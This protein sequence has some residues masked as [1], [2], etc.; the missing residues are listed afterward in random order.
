MRLSIAQS[1]LQN[2]VYAAAQWDM[3]DYSNTTATNPTGYVISS[4]PAVS[5]PLTVNYYEDYTAPGQPAYTV[6]TTAVTA[7]KGLLTATRTAVLNN[8]SDMLWTIDYYDGLGRVIQTYKEHYLGGT[9]STGNYDAVA[10]TYDFMNQPLTVSRQHYTAAKG[11]SPALTIS[12]TYVYDHTERR[13]QT[14]EQL[15][16]G[17]NVQLSE[18]EYNEIGQLRT[19]NLHYINNGQSQGVNITLG[20]ADAVASGS[21]T[22]IASGS[23]QLNPGFSVALNANFS[24]Q[25]STYEQSVSYTYNE[26]GWLLS[27]SAP[28]FSMQLGYNSGSSPQYNGNISSQS[29]TSA[30]S[31]GSFNYQYDALNRLQSGATAD[32]QYIER[33]ISYDVE[34]NIKTLSRVYGGTLVDS[35]SYAYNDASCNAT[36]QFQTITDLSADAGPSGYKT[37]TNGYLYDNNGN[38]VADDSK[39]ITGT[40]GI[41]YNLLNLPQSI[42]AKGTVYTYSASGEKLRR[43]VTTGGTTQYTDYVDGIEYDGTGNTNEAITFIQ[44]EEGRALPN[45]SDWNYEYNLSDHLGDTRLTFDSSTGSARTEQQDNYLPFGMDIS[46]GTIN[47]P[48]NYYLYNKKEAQP[49]WNV[50]D[51]GARFYDPVIGRWTSVD[52]AVED[53]QETAT[54]YGYVGMTLLNSQTRMRMAENLRQVGTGFGAGFEL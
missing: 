42:S 52:P 10:T 27:S 50:Y 38:M 20:A 47:S 54:P 11:T 46:V 37:G 6:P 48:Q 16:G 25:I 35:L 7:V 33:R 49:S 8:P 13:K 51:Y 3:L 23:I 32:G 12:N 39:G 30:K 31:T 43:A 44:T 45:G 4:Y 26:R 36:N 40:S 1:T 2:S 41:V 21:K 28:L 15:N 53:G 34:G 14:W 19:R 22:V 24:A 29:W 5:T 9:V 18:L 17:A